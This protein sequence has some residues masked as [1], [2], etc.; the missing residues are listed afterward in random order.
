M[1]KRPPIPWAQARAAARAG[2]GRGG[3][4]SLLKQSSPLLLAGGDRRPL[5]AEKAEPEGR[6]CELCRGLSGAGGSASSLEAAADVSSSGRDDAGGRSPVRTSSPPPSPG[7]VAAAGGKPGSL[8][9]CL[10]ATASSSSAGGVVVVL[11]PFPVCGCPTTAAVPSKPA[12]ATSTSMP[13]SMSSSA[14]WVPGVVGEARPQ[15]ISLLLQL[16]QG[17]GSVAAEAEA[18]GPG[19]EEEEEDGGG[20]ARAAWAGVEAG[21]GASVGGGDLSAC[22]RRCCR[23]HFLARRTFIPLACILVF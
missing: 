6:C 3:D 16:S 2:D 8:S 7:V 5:E 14:P 1:P 12:G 10:L 19:E 17:A 23:R 4:E 21:V 15:L 18:D 13:A 9:S 20:G 11:L 22:P